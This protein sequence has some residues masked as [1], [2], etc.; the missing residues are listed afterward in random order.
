MS[1]NTIQS[2]AKIGRLGLVNGQ[3][4]LERIIYKLVAL[5]G[6]FLL[7]FF[8]GP[9]RFGLKAFRARYTCSIKSSKVDILGDHQP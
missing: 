9:D 6:L 8:Q 4:G 2:A 5:N 7:E 1:Q 3:G